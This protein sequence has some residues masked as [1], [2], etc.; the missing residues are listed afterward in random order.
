M[1]NAVTK[2]GTVVCDGIHTSD[3]PSFPCHLLWEARAVRSVAN[4]TRR[5]GKE[6][7]TL[8]S[9]VQMQVKDQVFSLNQASDALNQ[10][11]AGKIDGAAVLS[12][13]VA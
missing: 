4:L 1:L 9:K 12:M 6:F 8:A 11:R 2:G 5:N 3:L 7:L 13:G 10:P